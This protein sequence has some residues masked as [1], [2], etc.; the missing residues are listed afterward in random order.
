MLRVTPDS[1][2]AR[3][4]VEPG[5]RL[6]EVAGAEIP[7]ILAY[8]R[9]LERG[10]VTLTLEDGAGARHSFEVAW[11]DPGL[12]F[13]DV[14]FDGLR[15]CA[16][17]CD[18]CYIHQMPKGFRKSLYVMDDD[19]RTSFLYGSFVTLTNL[20]E[21]DIERILDEHLS[22]LYVSVHTADEAL[23]GDLMKPWRLKVKDPAAVRIRTMIE[24]L[25]P[26]D[27]YAQMVLLPG[28]NDGEAM[29]DTLAYLA[30]RPNVHAVAGVPVGL[31]DHR[32][33]LP[34]LRAYQQ[35][36][37]DDVVR[38]VAAIQRRMLEERGTRFVFL[39]DE[40]YLAAGRPLPTAEAYEGFP[41][42]ENGVGMVRD[43]LGGG[44]PSL[45]ASLP[46]PRR[47]LLA[48]GTLFAPV[49]E[50]AVEPLRA[51]EGLELEVRALENRTFGSVT[52]V[53]GL[54]AGR[55][56]LLGVEPGEADLLLVSPN[57]L[58][59]GTETMLDDRTL[60][61]L[62]SALGM[63]V[64]AGGTDL[65]ELVHAILT[66]LG[67]RHVPQFGFSTHAIKESAKQH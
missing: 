63:A 39:S 25:E 1:P 64:E 57:V 37:A 34:D 5:W 56:F 20:T 42:L 9:E 45:P 27:L 54:L 3:A 23:R 52:N 51:I 59:Y 46:S 41:M 62:R 36:E 49:L 48:T 10:E 58:K 53:A 6:I 67:E 33:N 4:G 24:R 12:E 55:D 22:P 16:N 50:R 30:S 65:R 60:D 35:A 29:E 18:F 13:D 8:R 11:E 43:F 32:T 38:R 17:K 19:F 40:F 7:D 28:R 44:L 31:T 15:L 47:V 14:I 66:G 26:I 61:D 21:D 2:A